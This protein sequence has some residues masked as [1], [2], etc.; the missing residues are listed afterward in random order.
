MYSV[1]KAYAISLQLTTWKPCYF[2][3]YSLDFKHSGWILDTG[4]LSFF[5]D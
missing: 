4:N 3:T 2:S 1:T 5:M